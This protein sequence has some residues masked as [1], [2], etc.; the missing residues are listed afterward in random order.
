ML[1]RQQLATALDSIG[2]V[3]KATLELYTAPLNEHG[4]LVEAEGVPMAGRAIDKGL[5]DTVWPLHQM[6][7]QAG[8][9]THVRRSICSGR[10]A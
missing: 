3:L 8:G 4:K 6:I 1:A 9:A 7:M 2:Q 5:Y 10:G